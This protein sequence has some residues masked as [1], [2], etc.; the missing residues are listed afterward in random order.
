M[1]RITTNKNNIAVLTD[2]ADEMDN[3]K[4]RI[5]E[6]EK[7]TAELNANFVDLRVSNDQS[8]ESLVTG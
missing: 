6:L 7:L 4:P 5:L 8:I 2:R 1:F 3:W